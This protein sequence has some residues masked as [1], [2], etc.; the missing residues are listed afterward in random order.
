MLQRTTEMCLLF[1]SV[2]TSTGSSCSASPLDGKHVVGLR[3]LPKG[4]AV[5]ECLEDVKPVA[6][7]LP[8]HFCLFPP[9]AHPGLYLSSWIT[10]PS[11]LTSNRG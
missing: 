8:D 9:S 7:Q 10:T 1:L 2:E 5:G 3:A 4:P 11:P 6:L